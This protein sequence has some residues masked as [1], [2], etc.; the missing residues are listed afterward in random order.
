MNINGYHF[1]FRGVK[2]TAIDADGL[3]QLI[4]R[5]LRKQEKGYF[6]LTDVGNLIM[7]QKNTQLAAAINNSTASIADG[8]P[9]AWYGKLS[10]RKNIQRIS[11][12]ELFQRLINHTNYSHFLLGDTEE[13]QSK[14]IDKAKRTKSD[15][16]MSGFSPPFRSEFSAY[17][18][19]IILNRICQKQPEI[20]WV[21]FGGG[22]QEKWMFDHIASLD[23]GIMIGIGAALKY[24]IGDL[25]IPPAYIQRLGLQWITRL[26]KNPRRWTTKGP[27]KFRVLFTMQFLQELIKI[28]SKRYKQNHLNQ[29]K[30]K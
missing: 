2:I 25:Q 20:I 15:I 11:G 8:M 5:I 23:R 26:A 6:C 3:Q 24:Y 13:T 29:C 4:D 1:F 10:G 19:K 22:K 17:D 14:V 16:K 12:V 9:L 18:N 7:A 30:E 28:K 21:S 27:L